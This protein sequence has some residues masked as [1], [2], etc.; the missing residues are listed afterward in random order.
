[1]GARKLY[2]DEIKAFIAS[3]KDEDLAKIVSIIKTMKLEKLERSSLAIDE[4]FGKYAHVKTSSEAFADRK[5]PN[6]VLLSLDEK[7]AFTHDV[8][9]NYKGSSDQFMNNKAI[10]KL[11][12]R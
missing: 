8:F 7:I 2:E 9:K 1:M 6:A 4:A 5:E 12:D 10:E 3:S 11:L